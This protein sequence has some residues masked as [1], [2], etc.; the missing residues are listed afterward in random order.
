MTAARARIDGRTL[1][2]VPGETLLEAAA[3]LGIAIPTLC[4]V[5]GLPPD[6]GCRVCLVEVS[7][8]RRPLAACHT[9]ARDGMDVRTTTPALESLRAA[10]RALADAGRPSGPRE[11]SHPYLRFDP[12]C[13][14]I[15]RRCLH[16]CED[17]QGQF[18]YDVAG[19]GHETR[20]I[21]GHDEHFS[22]SP[23]TSCGACVEVC[24]TGAL[25]DVDGERGVPIGDVRTTLSTCGYCG[26]GCQVEIESDAR[27]VR[28]IHGVASAAVNR[29][30]LCAKGRYAHGW[31]ESPARLT[32]PLLR[33]GGRLVPVGWEEAI[34]FAAR[35]LAEIHV[36]HGADS[37]AALTSSRSTNEA[38]YL[39][40]KLFRSRFGTNNVDC[41]A[42]VC[43]ASTAQALRMA[44][45]AGAASASA[46]C[47]AW[48]SAS[49]LA[50]NAIASSQPTGT[51]R[52][53][54]RR[55]G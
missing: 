41:C 12:E 31:R 27:A 23:C 14:I 21:F 6:G 37:L 33:R 19:R 44:T 11:A 13:C 42:R 1:E 34:A 3:R 4:H 8:A 51:S 40:Q 46:P 26:V 35:R 43:H 16:V 28:R 36:A 55:S 10:V 22:T 5:P 54:R 49:R 50:A 15:C 24:P 17:V 20:L 53:S 52:P 48:I 29:G 30:H 7:G 9:P 32:Q 39:L 38:A 2:L 45:G 18:V 25:G 47:V